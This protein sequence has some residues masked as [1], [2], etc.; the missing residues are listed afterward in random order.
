MPINAPVAGVVAE[1]R[2]TLGQNVHTGD[3]LLRLE[4]RSFELQV[5]EAN[6]TLKADEAVLA[7]LKS[8]LSVERD[9]RDVMTGVVASTRRAGEARVEA[10]REASRLKQQETD[11]ITKLADAELAPK[12]ESLHSVS[13]TEERRLQIRV[14]SVQA[15]LDTSTAKMTLEDRNI[16]VANLAFQVVS[17]ENALQVETGQA[18]HP[19]IR[20]RTA[21]RTGAGRWRPHRCGRLRAGDD[22]HRRDA[23]RHPFAARRGARRRLLRATRRGGSGQAGA[24]GDHPRGKLPLDAIRHPAR[25]GAASRV[26][27][28]RRARA[29]GARRGGR[30][31]RYSRAPR[32]RCGR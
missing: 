1:C 30:K 31:R 24:A 5:A 20:G 18:Q 11:M 13:D 32:P 25:C 8:Q 9:A 16:R 26:R 19:R 14:S 15:A 3:L 7:G 12:L 10:N 29:S 6:A 22:R 17:A 21:L 27:A 4:S 2:A 23:H 28:P